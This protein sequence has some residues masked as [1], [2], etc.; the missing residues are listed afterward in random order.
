MHGLRD[1]E[2]ERQ[3]E[4]ALSRETLIVLHRKAKGALAEIALVVRTLSEQ[5]DKV[6]KIC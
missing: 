2:K 6:N 1:A 4:I 5:L 3:E